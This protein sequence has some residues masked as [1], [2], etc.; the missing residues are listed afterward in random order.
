MNKDVK[1]YFAAVPKDRRPLVMELHEFILGIYPEA[2]PVLWY[3]MPTYRAKKG[4]VALG[5]WKGGATIYTNQY[6]HTA[7]FKAQNPAFK[8]GKASIQFKLGE[9]LPAVALKKFIK[10]VMEKPG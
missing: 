9:P 6:A 2:E 8:T 10:L 3:S 5:Y 7:Q 4:W 1:E